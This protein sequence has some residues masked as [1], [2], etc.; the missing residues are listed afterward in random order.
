MA[1]PYDVLLRIVRF[2]AGA[3]LLADRATPQRLLDVAVLHNDRCL[4][5]VS[6]ERLA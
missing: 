3:F 5:F 1:L 6:L 2:E 4:R